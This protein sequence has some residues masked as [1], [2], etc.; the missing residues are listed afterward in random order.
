MIGKYVEGYGD[1]LRN[2][3]ISI[4]L[5]VP[6]IAVPSII[7]EGLPN[8]RNVDGVRKTINWFG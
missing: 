5:I 7:Y 3:I 1:S 4:S 2:E 8:G 6:A